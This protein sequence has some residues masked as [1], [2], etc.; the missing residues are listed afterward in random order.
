MR[1]E[2]NETYVNPMEKTMSFFVDSNLVQGHEPH[3][4]VHH[5]ADGQ[6]SAAVAAFQEE[7]DANA[8]AV[9]RNE[10]GQA[11]G[12]DCSYKVL[13]VAEGVVIDKEKGKEMLEARKAALLLSSINAS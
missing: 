9:D 2:A 6:Y 3:A 5:H 4:V 10:R 7:S 1:S 8:D 11:L 13:P 12:L